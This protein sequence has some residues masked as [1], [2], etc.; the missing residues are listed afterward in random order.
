MTKLELATIKALSKEIEYLKEFVDYL[1]TQF[2]HTLKLS[3]IEKK[4]LHQDEIV[5]A[6]KDEL[7]ESIRLL[8]ERI[9]G[10]DIQYM[11]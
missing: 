3:E 10:I 8:E 6:F 9:D 11:T 1:D 7:Q 4:I 2:D 5:D